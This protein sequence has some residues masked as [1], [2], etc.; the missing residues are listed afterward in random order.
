MK[1]F[2]I[3]VAIL[4][5]L[6]LMTAFSQAARVAAAECS[7]CTQ[8]WIAPTDC[9][10]PVEV[11]TSMSCCAEGQAAPPE[12]CPHNGFCQGDKTIPLV[13]ST[14]TGLTVDVSLSSTAIKNALNTRQI[15]L[16]NPQIVRPPPPQR[17]PFI[18]LFHCAFLI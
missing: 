16:N 15:L 6:P 11:T 7:H 17:Y 13:V 4:V 8:Q 10:A 5:L 3:F 1:R 2:S 9:C 14:V 12:T 18:Y